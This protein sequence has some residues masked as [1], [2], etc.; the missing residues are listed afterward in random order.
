[1]GDGRHTA[2]T[3]LKC[4][5][6]LRGGAQ[7]TCRACKSS[8][9]RQLH[10]LEGEGILLLSLSPSLHKTIYWDGT[11]IENWRCSIKSTQLHNTVEPTLQEGTTSLQRTFISAPKMNFPTRLILLTSASLERMVPKCRRFHCIP[12]EHCLPSN[13]TYT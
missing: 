11:K 13:M 2:G 5:G 3:W 1:M 4:D 8:I 7:V 12:C 10:L 9:S 6:V